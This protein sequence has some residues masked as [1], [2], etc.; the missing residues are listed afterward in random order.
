MTLHLSNLNIIFVIALLISCTACS[1]NNSDA[2]QAHAITKFAEQNT[3]SNS[4][5]SSELIIDTANSSALNLSNLDSKEKALRTDAGV[6]IY[7]HYC[8]HCHNPGEGH[9]G[10]MRLAI[11]LSP[12]QAIIR[13]RE[14]LPAAY[15]KQIVR[16]GLGMMPAFRPTEIS[17]TDLNSL[18]GYIVQP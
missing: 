17:D 15:V 16:N 4:Q 9:P 14:N 18:I 8:G 1:D 10:T 7:D 2:N 12:D 3:N 11:R 5:A 6:A 13:Q